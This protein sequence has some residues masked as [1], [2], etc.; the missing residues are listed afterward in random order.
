P[1]NRA[2]GR[3]TR[4]R[5]QAARRLLRPG[6]CSPSRDS[7]LGRDR[8]PRSVERRAERVPGQGG[9]LHARRELHTP[10]STASFPNSW[11][12]TLLFGPSLTIEWTRW[13]SAT[14]SALV[15]FFS[16][17]VISEAEA[18]EMAQPAPWKPM[19]SITSPASFR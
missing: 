3:W 8:R 18:L 6:A 19:S 1:G 11:G 2:R 5:P 17:E 4:S 13:K 7:S 10:E 9:A 14:A 12:S 15:L 16:A